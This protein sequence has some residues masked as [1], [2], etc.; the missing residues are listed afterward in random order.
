M[1]SLQLRCETIKR[2]AMNQGEIP[3]WLKPNLVG[4]W[5]GQKRG[6]VYYPLT[7]LVTNGNFAGGTTGW[8]TTVSNASVESNTLY[9]TGTGAGATPYINQ[10]TVNLIANH[11]YCL[12][13][14]VRVTSANAI[15][16]Q[17]KITSVSGDIGE[18]NQ[19][20]PVQ[21]QWYTMILA[22]DNVSYTT[23]L[24]V[25][26]A[27]WYADAATASGKVMEVQNVMTYDLTAIFG[28]GNEPTA[29]EMDAIL[30]A[31]GTPYWDGTRNVLCNPNGKYFWYGENGRHMKMSNLAYAAGS[32]LDANGFDVDGV[33]DYGSIADSA[34][35]RL[36]GGGTLMAW[37]K[38]RGL[39]EATVGRIFDK[40]TGNNG[41]NG[42]FMSMYPDNKLR[43]RINNTTETISTINAITLNI[44]NFAVYTFNMSGKRLY[45]NGINVTNIGGTDSNMPPNVAGNVYIGN[46]N[47]TSFSFNGLIDK[48]M[49]INRALT[50]AEVQ[51]IFGMTRRYYGV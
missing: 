39:G 32:N 42:Y 46:H 18:Y 45:V 49:I 47:T 16:I 29:A 34:A 44:W 28:A 17:I 10:T 30:A 40:S 6:N 11:K 1:N 21:N 13:A 7:N 8:A 27:H 36:T 37:I 50:Q 35:T 43:G 19:M 12:I 15:R 4:Y 23:S 24:Q 5:S 25:R 33:D 22:K 38:P 20:S 26:I 14:R 31:D 41:E 9:N 51:Q 2:I 48:P 3:Q